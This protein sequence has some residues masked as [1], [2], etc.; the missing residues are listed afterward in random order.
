MTFVVVLLLAI[1]FDIPAMAAAV[2][3]VA[4]IAGCVEYYARATRRTG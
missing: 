1:A 3:V 4:V 2:L